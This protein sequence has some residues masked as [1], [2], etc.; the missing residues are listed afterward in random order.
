MIPNRMFAPKFPDLHN[1][2]LWTPVW[3]LLG[4]F[5]LDVVEDAIG[6]NAAGAP[7]TRSIV[8]LTILV[9]M[10]MANVVLVNLL[11]AQMSS[12]YE[13]LMEVA[14]EEWIFNRAHL[15]LEFKDSKRTLPPPLNIFTL[16]L[17]DVPSL[18]IWICRGIRPRPPGG[19]ASILHGFKYY[20]PPRVLLWAM[21]RE[22]AACAKVVKDMSRED[23]IEHK[24][25]D[26]HNQLKDGQAGL[27]R[28]VAELNA[29]LDRMVRRIPGGIAPSHR[30]RTAS[31]AS[32][33]RSSIARQPR[34]STAFA[35]PQAEYLPPVRTTPGPATLPPNHAPAFLASLP[36]ITAAADAV[37]VA[38]FYL[39][40]S[41]FRIRLAS[42]ASTAERNAYLSAHRGA[43]T[44]IRN[45]RST[46]VHVHEPPFYGRDDAP[47]SWAL[48][49]SDTA[50]GFRIR[51]V[52]SAP[53]VPA[54][55]YLN[56]HRNGSGA[57]DS[58]TPSSTYVHVHEQ[59]AGRS[60]LA[61]EWVLEPA[62]GTADA[63]RIRLDSDFHGATAGWYLS[64]HCKADCP[65]VRSAVSTYVHVFRLNED[66]DLGPSRWVMEPVY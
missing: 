53:G 6:W 25:D 42:D 36:P 31:L 38:E 58:R 16:L 9:Y 35:A 37:S 45:S 8:P 24:V 13:A 60:D 55:Q 34:T 50:G 59:G 65:D 44:D 43:S 28:S 48:E 40:T 7:P 63:Y 26:M 21:Q 12:T 39:R 11:I 5:D 18:L 46:Y 19:S 2:P 49:P 51:L 56:V 52:S 15:I 22:C 30:K 29:K 41:A 23:S 1:S 54:G 20:S 14:T 62:E 3:G 64:V 47:S 32:A 66:S 4:D 57:M 17:W 27:E 61:S 10:L 33:P